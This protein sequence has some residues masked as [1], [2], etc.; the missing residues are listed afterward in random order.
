MPPGLA[1]PGPGGAPGAAPPPGGGAPPAPPMGAMASDENDDM[2]KVAQLSL[3][4]DPSQQSVD[5]SMRVY[6]RGKQP[7]QK[8]SDE[9]TV[10]N[11]QIFLTKPEQKLFSIVKSLNVPLRLFAQY[12]FKV[13]GEQ[14]AYLLD[15]AFPDIMLNFEADGDFW[16]SDASAVERDKQRDMKLAS[17]GWRVVRI[18]ES[19]LNTNVELVTQIIVNNIKDTIAQRKALMAKR[20]SVNAEDSIYYE[21]GDELKISYQNLIYDNSDNS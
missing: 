4:N 13:P 6:K 20:A 9:P 2:T 15:F 17:M 7:K 8:K 14:N 5:P 11:K 3:M 16:H 12:E 10:E 18:K 21:D 1:G 19:A